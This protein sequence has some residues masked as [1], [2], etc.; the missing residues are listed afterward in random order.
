MFNVTNNDVTNY[1]GCGIPHNW[2][3]TSGKFG[4]LPTLVAFQKMNLQGRNKL[5]VWSM[6]ANKFTEA[7]HTIGCK[8]PQGIVC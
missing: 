1:C 2:D 3:M 7:P 5:I 6:S 4:G 8:I